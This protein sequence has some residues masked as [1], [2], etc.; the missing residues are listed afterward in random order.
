MQYHGDPHGADA[1]PL[2]L[3]ARRL[4]KGK[5]RFLSRGNENDARIALPVAPTS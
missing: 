3:R 1:G 2:R 5:L 4:L